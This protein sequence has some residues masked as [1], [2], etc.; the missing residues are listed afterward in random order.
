MSSDIQKR[1]L[2]GRI[3]FAVLFLAISVLLLSQIGSQAKF[4]SAG[5]LFA[6][7][8]FWPAVSLFGMVFFA[9]AH[10]IVLL[11]RGGHNEEGDGRDQLAEQ[12]FGRFEWLRLA[13]FFGWFMVYV[14]LVPRAGYLPATVLFSVALA[15]R[16]GYRT[17]PMLGISALMGTIVVLVFKTFLAVRI[18]GG[19]IYELLPDALRNFMIGNF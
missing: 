19:E 12:G 17:L 7:P 4:S 16:V 15:Y 10:I 8:A 18:P 3:L 2:N 14:T 6:Q 1:R 5:K 13:E 9:I 11:R